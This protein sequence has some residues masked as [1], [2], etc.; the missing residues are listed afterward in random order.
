VT[1]VS[2]NY[3]VNKRIQPFTAKPDA[4]WSIGQEDVERLE[5]LSID[6]RRGLWTM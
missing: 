2:W 3:E 5:E 1:D 4:D 6:C